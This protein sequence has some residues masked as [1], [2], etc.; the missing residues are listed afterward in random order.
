MM[1]YEKDKLLALF[2][3]ENRWC[4]CFEARDR[5]GK[6]VRY[7]DK[8]ATAWDVVGGMCFL[9]GWERACKL[10]AQAGR[11]ITGVKRVAGLRDH[12]MAAMASLLDFNDRHDT[13]YDLVIAK[14]RD[15]RVHCRR[16]PPLG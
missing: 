3:D 7:N 10:F 15:M 4:Q 13:T 12:E 16:L 1:Q 14:L 9:F 8:A 6:P 11:Q 2:E 5:S